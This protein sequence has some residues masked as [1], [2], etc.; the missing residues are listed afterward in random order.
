MEN[1]KYYEDFSIEMKV[2]L[3]NYKVTKEE[4][5]EF[6]SKYDPQPFHINE[7]KLKIQCL[8]GS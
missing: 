2:D 3:G 8:A 1:K 4:I 5:L 7:K 6:A